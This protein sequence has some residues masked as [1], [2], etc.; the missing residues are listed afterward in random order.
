MRPYNRITWFENKSRR[1]MLLEFQRD[2]NDY[3]QS[4]ET[5]RKDRIP[6]YVIEGS[7]SKAI[8]TKINRNLSQAKKT[9]EAS[10]VPC[11]VLDGIFSSFSVAHFGAENQHFANIE[12]C[13]DQSIGVY[14]SSI[15]A[16]IWRT[17][18]PLTYVSYLTSWLL[19]EIEVTLSLKPGKITGTVIGKLGEAIL[20]L[21]IAGVATYLTWENW[22]AF[23]AWV[24]KLYS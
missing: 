15:R 11:D 9:I 20:N 13:I 8:R 16:S 12:S 5:I 19:Q 18:W 7:G 2:V 14:E 24:T 10:K 21:A 1:K 17:V 6:D 23:V 4:L 3:H 22:S